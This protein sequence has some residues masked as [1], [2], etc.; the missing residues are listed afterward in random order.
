[1]WDLEGRSQEL[2]QIP[3]GVDRVYGGNNASIAYLLTNLP[4]SR[5]FINILLKIG[6]KGIFLKFLVTK[7]L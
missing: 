4:Q 5:T 7:C 6:L 2:L 3:K 1:M